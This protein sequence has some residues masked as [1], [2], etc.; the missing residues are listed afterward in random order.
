MLSIFSL[1]SYHD[2]SAECEPDGGWIM[3]A[4]LTYP[5]ELYFYFSCCSQR[6]FIWTLRY[7]VFVTFLYL[8]LNIGCNRFGITCA[9]PIQQSYEIIELTLP[10]KSNS[11]KISQVIILILLTSSINK[12]TWGSPLEGG[13]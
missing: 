8:F 3:G 5:N 7:V 13:D 4:N 2:N 12:V 9:V 6:D 10:L 11:I 1:G